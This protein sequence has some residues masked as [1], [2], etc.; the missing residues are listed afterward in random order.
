MSPNLL[1]TSYDTDEDISPARKATALPE[2]KLK[3]R[4]IAS[5]LLKCVVNIDS[6]TNVKYLADVGF[7][8]VWMVRYDLILVT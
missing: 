4:V 6:F 2:K 7:C 5:N 1:D 8:D 3:E